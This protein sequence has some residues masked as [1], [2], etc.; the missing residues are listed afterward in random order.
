MANLHP[1]VTVLDHILPSDKATEPTTV[2]PVLWARLDAI[3]LQWIYG[4][5]SNDLLHTILKP[6]STAA[7]TWQ[8]LANIFQDYKTSRAL[9]LQ[10]RFYNK[11]LDSFPTASAYCQQLK[12]LSDQLAN[13][14][15]PVSDSQLVLQLING[16]TG[17]KLDGIGMM[18]QQTSPLPNFY[19]S[20]SRLILE[21]T[22]QAQQS[23][24]DT[25]LHATTTVPAVSHA[26]GTSSLHPQTYHNSHTNSDF[27]RVQSRG[28]GRG[29]RGRGRRHNSSRGQA[30]P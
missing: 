5:I 13:V 23:Q 27:H 7:Q 24:T 20:R 19:T 30:G 2:D 3:V 26:P 22:R 15:A 6:K 9:H 8:A 18:L 17:S 25:A 4:T 14:D 28:R 11:K 21:E 1:A 12:V 29:G 16:L 10:S